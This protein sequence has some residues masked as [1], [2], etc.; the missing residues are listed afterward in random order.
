MNYVHLKP[1]TRSAEAEPLVD[2]DLF[3]DRGIPVKLDRLHGE[4]FA[5]ETYSQAGKIQGSLIWV[6]GLSFDDIISEI[7]DKDFRSTCMDDEDGQ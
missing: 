1:P 2:I 5:M 6:P 3:E 4:G 7:S